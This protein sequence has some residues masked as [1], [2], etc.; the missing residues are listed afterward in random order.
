MHRSQK[1]RYWLIAAFAAETFCV[2]YGL[3]FAPLAPVFSLLYF[4]AGVAIA[5]L[6]LY[7][8]EAK[9]AS[10]KQA[11]QTS[12]SYR[13]KILFLIGF[14][15]L[16]YYMCRYLFDTTPI[17]IN[18]A[19]MLPVINKMGQRF[20]NGQWKHVYDSIPEI[21]NGTK[22]IY[23]PA[24]WLPFS[25][26]VMFNIDIRWVTAAC[27]LFVFSVAY[28]ILHPSRD[29]IFSFITLIIAFILFWWLMTE[30][31]T[32]GFISLSEEGVIVA[33]Y[34][35]LVIAILSGNIYF[36]GIAIS[37]CVLSRYAVIGWV[38]AF[39]IYLL[40]HKKIKELF[41]LIAVGVV[42][43]FGF[44]ILPFGWNNFIQL[45]QLP[46]NYVEFAGRV[47]RDSPEVFSESMGFAKFFGP[48]NINALHHTLIAVTF[49]VPTC[50]VVYCF[51]KSSK[52][53]ISN[54][55]LASLKLGVVFFYNFIDVPYLYLFYTS[56]FISLVA[57]SFFVSK[58]F[59]EPDA[60]I[61]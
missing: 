39:L 17:D 35:L 38:P 27:L 22:P 2:T 61:V 41:I 47:W 44:F 26:P 13:Y 16:L 9:M 14:G 34:T 45:L 30:N 21:W 50:F 52:K 18:A 23:L 19:D 37:L 12:F 31:D 58:D 48:G 56:S 25:V 53:N 43:F 59:G 40:L 10:K 57:V 3:K 28:F 32:H 24:T 5:L 54:I 49:I 46:G 11:L 60:G 36:M 7:F 20:V 6:F 29:R 8:P 15:A 51:Y 33:Y 4:F 1:L 42:F 55:A